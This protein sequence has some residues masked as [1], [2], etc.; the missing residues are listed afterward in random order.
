[1][2]TYLWYQHMAQE[3]LL[4]TTFDI[5]ELKGIPLCFQK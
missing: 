1:M 2:F 3:P 4:G 5:A